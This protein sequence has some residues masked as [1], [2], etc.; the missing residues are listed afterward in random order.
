MMRLG[1]ISHIMKDKETAVLHSDRPISKIIKKKVVD[2]KVNLIGRVYDIFGP[3]KNHYVVIKLNKN[4][5]INNISNK[6]LY[7]YSK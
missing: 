1:S 4:I 5:N 3:I 6:I 7:I 2:E